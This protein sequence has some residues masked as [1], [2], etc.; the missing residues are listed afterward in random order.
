MY[1]YGD[2]AIIII[3]ERKLNDISLVLS[4]LNL[5]ELL[6]DNTTELRLIPLL[7]GF[8]VTPP[9]CVLVQRHIY[10]RKSNGNTQEAVPEM[11]E[12]LFTGTLSLKKTKRNNDSALPYCQ[13]TSHS[14]MSN[15]PKSVY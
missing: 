2:L 1:S 10:S 7:S 13:I 4:T 14:H 9:C 15:S 12:K 6:C 5:N 3:L 8:R 11:T